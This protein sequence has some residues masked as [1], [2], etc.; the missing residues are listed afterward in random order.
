MQRLLQH[1]RWILV[2]ACFTPALLAQETTAPAAATGEAAKTQAAAA[3][4]ASGQVPPPRPPDFLENIVDAI[5]EAFDIR[6]S[7]NTTT[8]YAV[9]AGMLVLALL[10]RRVVTLFIFPLFKRVSARTR[11]TFDD[12]LFAALETPVAAF[13]MLVGIFAALRV[14]KLSPS[15]DEAISYG[16]RV[17]FVI[18]TFWLIWRG[19]KAVLDHTAEVAR[20]KGLPVAHF[21]PW[22]KKSLMALFVI[23]SVLLTMQSLGYNVKA[24]LAGLGIGGLAFALAAQDTLANIFGAIVVAVDQPFKLGEAV[25]IQGNVG[26]VEDIG[27]RST[28]IRMVD[29][30]LMVIPNKIV[31][32]ETITNLSRFIRRRFEHIVLLPHGTAPE[33]MDEM[34]EVIRGIIK[35]QPEVDGGGVMVFFRDIT[36]TALEIWAAWETV[37]PDFPAAMTCKQRINTL[38]MKALAERKLS[39]AYPTQNV[40]LTAP[41]PE[42]LASPQ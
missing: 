39:Y 3:A 14:L 36:P 8:H 34:V 15:A 33:M 42:S 25:R 41:H 31:A 27:V 23:L 21:M 1:F 17:A 35:A 37:S 30:S 19:V 29:K 13:I 32:S 20:H 40:Q 4:V 2:L 10:A 22:I 11:T 9:A 24:I 12:R 16:S 38:I 26:V 7:G 28:R 18:A 5:L 6:V